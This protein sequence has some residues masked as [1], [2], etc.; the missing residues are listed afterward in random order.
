MNWVC[1]WNWFDVL[2]LKTIDFGWNENV[3]YGTDWF[4]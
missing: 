1:W 2:M 3:L 4:D